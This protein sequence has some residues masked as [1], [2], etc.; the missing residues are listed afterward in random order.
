MAAGNDQHM[1]GCQRKAIGEGSG[2]SV[3]GDQFG[4][5]GVLAH[6]AGHRA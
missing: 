5:T 2:E 6:D 4:A 1:T 3:R